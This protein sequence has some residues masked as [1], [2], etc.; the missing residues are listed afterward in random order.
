MKHT[1]AGF[2]NREGNNLYYQNWLPHNKPK[3]ILLIVHGLAEHSGRYSNVIN[4]FIPRGY[5]AY[6]FDYRGHGK[7]GGKRGYIE[8]FS[9]YL[10]DLESFLDLVR[11]K[12]SENSVFI[13]GHSVGATIAATFAINHQDEFNGL[14]LS[15]TVIK[16][17]TSLSRVKIIMANLLS[18]IL[19]KIGVD[20]LD[21]STISQD[22]TVV[23]N[24]VNDSLVY[25]GKISARL[26]AELIKAMQNLTYQMP[27]IKLPLLI[28]HGTSDRLSDPEG[29]QILYRQ[30]SSM[31]KTLKLY[32]GF[33]HEIFNEPGREKVFKDIEEWLYVHI[34]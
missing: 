24:Y 9:C 32:N 15:G 6:S 2:F 3:A 10:D 8:R 18:F 25:H 23:D 22:R 29:S 33:Y 30:V 21:A 27:Q 34:K 20:K 28:M 7:S 13:I 17:G 12:H 16:P 19:P 26:G 14:I 1:E 4:Y 5:A 31:D 11:S